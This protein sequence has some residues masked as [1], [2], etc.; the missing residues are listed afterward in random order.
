MKKLFCKLPPLQWVAFSLA[1]IASALQIAAMLLDIAPG[2]NYFIVG[3]PLPV[4]AP[5]VAILALGSGVAVLLPLKKKRLLAAYPAKLRKLHL[6]PAF[7]FFVA[8]GGLL[9][10]FIRKGVTLWEKHTDGEKFLAELLAGS[11]KITL[12]CLPLLLCAAFY[13]L[14]RALSKNENRTTVTLRGLATMVACGLLVTHIYFDFSIEL[15]APVRTMLQAGILSAVALFTAETRQLLNKP[16]ATLLWLTAELTLV[17]ATFSSVAIIVAYLTGTLPNNRFDHFC[18][19]IFLLF[20]IPAA[21]EHVL[22]I[23]IS[24]SEPDTERT[25]I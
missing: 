22:T 1:L 19:A 23:Q 6:F 7:G 21:L 4:I 8:F 9:R 20:M 2:S 25:S 10:F 24:S 18:Y 5:I 3:R 11:S 14:N 16:C 15:N 13:C 17:C 12:L